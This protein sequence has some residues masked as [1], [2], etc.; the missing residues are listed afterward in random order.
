MGTYKLV[1]K[2]INENNKN[3]CLDF[4]Y[5][6]YRLFQNPEKEMKYKIY[7]RFKKKITKQGNLYIPMI[8]DELLETKEINMINVL[9]RELNIPEAHI[10]NIRTNQIFEL[11]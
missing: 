1:I 6:V 10:K 4:A 5:I 8:K 3:K 2:G 9:F 7:N 11:K